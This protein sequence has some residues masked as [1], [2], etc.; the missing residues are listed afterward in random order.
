MKGNGNPLCNARAIQ[1]GNEKKNRGWERG[2]L[3]WLVPIVG[4]FRG[5]VGGGFSNVTSTGTAL[6]TSRPFLP[7]FFFPLKKEVKKREKGLHIRRRW[8]CFFELGGF[9][10][11][12]ELNSLHRG[13]ALET[14]PFL[15]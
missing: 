7:F 4:R 6:Y 14:P 1:P 15:F 11:I 5:L 3:G 13:L 12:I 8:F 2:V 10:H 9:I